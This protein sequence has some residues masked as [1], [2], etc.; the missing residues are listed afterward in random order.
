MGRTDVK[1]EAPILWPPDVMS[2]STG[3]DPD[4]RKDGRQQEKG[5]AEDEMAG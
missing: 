5:M 2:Q 4:V 3:K 1:V